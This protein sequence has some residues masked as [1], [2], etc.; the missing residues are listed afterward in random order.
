MNK[1]IKEKTR[2]IYLDNSATTRVEPEVKKEMD[3]YYEEVYGNPGSFHSLGLKAKKS[4]KDA[5]NRIANI[6][7]AKP[8]EIIFT[9]GGT[10]SINLA[11]KGLA[12]VQPKEKNHIITTTIEHHAVLDTCEYL[13]KKGFKVTYLNVDKQGILDPEDLKK[14]IKKE[15]FLVSIMYANNEVGTIQDIKKISSICKEKN[16]KFHTD[17]C[18]A[19]LYL[20]I[21]VNN[22]G[23]DMMSLNA[24]KTR[25]PKGVGL[26]YVRSSSILKLEPLIHG[27]G[28]E[29][30][31]RSGTENLQGIMGF[32]KALELAEKNKE[33]ESKRLTIL[34]N[35]LIKGIKE[36]TPKTFLNGHP[37]KRLPN[38]VNISFLDIE[39]ESIL[40]Y[41]DAKGIYASSGSACTSKTLDPSH[42]I[43][44]L[45]VPYE[46]A[47]GS[48]R[49]TLGKETTEQDIDY[50]VKVLPP[51]VKHLRE[52]SPFKLDEKEIRK[53]MELVI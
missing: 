32:A 47:H 30:G 16:V 24:S 31:L 42:V 20:D 38:N 35:R 46:I 40:L 11:I 2:N 50:V 44:A 1:Q 27:G 39:G 45:G 18:Q 19:S 4:L 17:A 37:A 52:I 22:L 26:L 51:I 53:K 36:N 23:I 48:I 14:A 34:R 33:K 29:R 15:T 41:L 12:E 6:L 25:G 21:N 9:G 8:K 43:L 10:E 13:E 3:F 28:Q 5:R 49:F 7:S